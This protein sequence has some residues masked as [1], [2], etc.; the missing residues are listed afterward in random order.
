[1]PL[2]FRS[3]GT[4]LLLRCC[5]IPFLWRAVHGRHMKTR[6]EM[7]V[8]RN[9]PSRTSSTASNMQH[10]HNMDLLKLEMCVVYY[11]LR[12]F[13]FAAKRKCRQKYEERKKCFTALRCLSAGMLHHVS[14]EKRDRLLRITRDCISYQSL[15]SY[16]ASIYLH[17]QSSSCAVLQ[18][19]HPAIS[20]NLTIHLSVSLSRYLTNKINDSPLLLLYYLHSNTVHYSHSLPLA[21]ALCLVH[22]TGHTSLARLSTALSEHKAVKH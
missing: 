9:M 6:N 12:H 8:T 18:C 3:P 20:H 16:I 14:H 19:C 5:A 17:E 1:M 21:C 2:F 10:T 13:L 22:V 7:C 15:S 11:F 4:A